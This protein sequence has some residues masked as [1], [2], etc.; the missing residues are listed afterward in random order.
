MNNMWLKELVNELNKI[1]KKY[2]KKIIE[3]YVLKYYLCNKE[4]T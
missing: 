4:K 2:L 1:N 3:E